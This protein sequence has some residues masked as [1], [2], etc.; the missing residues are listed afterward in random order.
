MHDMESFLTLNYVRKIYPNGKVA[1]KGMDL[2]VAAGEI[3]GLLGPNGAG[4]TTTIRMIIGALR[5]TSGRVSFNGQDVWTVSGKAARALKRS[6]GYLPERPVMFQKLTPVEF[7]TFIGELYGLD[8]SRIQY[9][10]EKY[11]DYFGL[12]ERRN[13]FLEKFS[14]GMRKKVA[15]I[16]AIIGNPAIVLLDEPFSDLDPESIFRMK[17]LIRDLKREGKAV[18]VSTH[19]LGLASELTDRVGIIHQGELLFSGTE[20]ELRN[21]LRQPEGVSLETLFLHLTGSEIASQE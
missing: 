13:E 5:P 16:A 12:L 21:R 4:K 2:A 20:A 7:M 10:I 8:D 18:V 11:L 3:F 1:V 19:F 9:T 17:K 14:A 6:I 15:T